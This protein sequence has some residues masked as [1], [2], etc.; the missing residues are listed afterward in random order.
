ML[1]DAEISKK[2]QGASSQ[3]LD[4][5]CLSVLLLP[6][7]NDPPRSF[8]FTSAD[9][10]SRIKDVIRRVLIVVMKNNNFLI[11]VLLSVW[12]DWVSYV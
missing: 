8:C 6:D 7:S 9:V 4:S 1:G 5:E 12:V 10:Q 11:A 2:I 3:H